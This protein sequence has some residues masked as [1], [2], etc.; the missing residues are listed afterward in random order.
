[1]SSPAVAIVVYEIATAYP[2]E[3]LGFN[4]EFFMGSVWLMFLVFLFL[5]P[6]VS[7]VNG[8]SFL[9]CPAVFTDVF[10]SSF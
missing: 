1:M 3:A 5:V 10:C 7:C 8:L 6:N 4:A 9:E 2:S